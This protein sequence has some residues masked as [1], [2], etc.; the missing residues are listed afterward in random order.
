MSAIPTTMRALALAAFGKPSTYD[1]AQLP[2][3]KISNPGE[4]LIR[5]KAA[6]IN[7]IDVKLAAGLAKM[8]R[9][10]TYVF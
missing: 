2:T 1:V 4:V 6:S 7:P 10:T 9:K 8:F 5:V 3:P